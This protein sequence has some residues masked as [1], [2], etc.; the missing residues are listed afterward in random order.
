MKKPDLDC[1]ES[2]LLLS[3][4]DDISNIVK[5]TY[6]HS[7]LIGV[8]IASPINRIYMYANVSHCFL[9]INMSFSKKVLFFVC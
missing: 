9:F 7:R 6:R 2:G 4:Y 5:E 3:L 1:S 8:T